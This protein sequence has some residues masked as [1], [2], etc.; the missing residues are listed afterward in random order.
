MPE[1]WLTHEYVGGGL[2]VDK[3]VRAGGGQDAVDRAILLSPH[4]PDPEILKE[5]IIQYATN[6][7]EEDGV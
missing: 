2:W 4:K 6:P 5:E 7:G 1:N 3:M